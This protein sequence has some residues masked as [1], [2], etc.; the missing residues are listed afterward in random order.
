MESLACLPLLDA[1]GRGDLIDVG[2]GGGFPGVPIK[3]ARPQLRIALIESRRMK[4][5][6]LQKAIERIHCPEIWAWQIRIERLAG[7]PPCEPDATL[8]A[9]AQRTS[10]LGGPDCRPRVDF[11]TARA[12]APLGTLLQWVEP[13]VR[14][15]GCVVAFKGSRVEEEILRWQRKPGPW[16]I[17]QFRQ[18]VGP[19]LN[20]LVARR[21]ASDP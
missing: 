14:P 7:L 20:L 8:R 19:N 6:F 17:D 12:V 10:D 2:A 15:G 11:V 1:L 9:A 3:L 4:S 5:L 16:T 13:L 21:Q 18:D